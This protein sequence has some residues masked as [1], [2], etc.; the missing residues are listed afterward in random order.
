M[1]ARTDYLPF[2]E[3]FE[4]SGNG[5]AEGFTGQ[6]RDGEAG[7]DYFHARMYQPRT[8]RFNTVDP[9]F[10]GLFDPQQWNRYSYARNAPLR[11]I[12]LWG[13]EI[14]DAAEGAKWCPPLSA[15]NPYDAE[16][17][18]AP[19][20]F[21]PTVPSAN[22]NDWGYQG[23]E[24]DLAEAGWDMAMSIQFFAGYEGAMGSSQP[25]PNVS[26]HLDVKLGSVSVLEEGTRLSPLAQLA[27]G[28]ED[29]AGPMSDPGT[30]A[31]LLGLSAAGGAGGAAA[32]LQ[33]EALATALLG[34]RGLLLGT[35]GIL[36]S[37]R[38]LRIGHSRFGGDAVLRASGECPK[39][40]PLNRL[41]WVEDGHWT[42]KNYGKL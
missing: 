40:W 16:H 3:T 15:P 11:F 19:T 4:A 21:A 30:Y 25:S 5:P 33:R 31:W 41:K 36:N 20:L 38:Y 9:V 17:S 14:C 13:R 26:V 12:D 10:A 35:R 22:P 34:R 23:G 7:L 6:A 2:G 8:G 37:N 32:A 39:K 42:F 1:V 27:I 28:I 24:L 18:A 29:R